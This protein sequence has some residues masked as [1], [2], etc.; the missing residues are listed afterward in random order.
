[1]EEEKKVLLYSSHI[2]ENEFVPFMDIDLAKKSQYA[3][4]F[5]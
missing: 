3:I 5:T 4:P 2:N 1:M